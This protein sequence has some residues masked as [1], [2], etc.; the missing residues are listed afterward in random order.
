MRLLDRLGGPLLSLV[1]DVDGNLAPAGTKVWTGTTS[2]GYAAAPF[3]GAPADCAGWTAARSPPRG[4]AG[5]PGDLQSW[6]ASF[7]GEFC[8]IPARLYCIED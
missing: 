1:P 8:E 6:S 3:D 4:A 5:D 7:Y 2:A